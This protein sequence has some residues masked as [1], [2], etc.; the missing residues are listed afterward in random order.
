MYVATKDSTF[1]HNQQIS[2]SLNPTGSEAN[3]E[4]LRL[5]AGP[6]PNCAATLAVI[7]ASSGFGSS[8]DSV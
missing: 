1:N 5:K 6:H 8:Q 2:D 4:T 3:Q 7:V